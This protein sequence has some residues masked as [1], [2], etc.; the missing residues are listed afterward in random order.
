MTID[1]TYVPTYYKSLWFTRM[2]PYKMI[3]VWS[4]ETPE[5]LEGKL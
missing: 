1:V 5:S 4:W 3:S 2:R